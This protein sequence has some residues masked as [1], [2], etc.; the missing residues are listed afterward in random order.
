MTGK[1]A[2]LRTSGI[3]GADL[4][5][6][7][8]SASVLGIGSLA[9]TWLDGWAF[10]G[11]V[12]IMAALVLREWR[13]LIG[14]EQSHTVAVA[15]LAAAIA[16]ILAGHQFGAGAAGIVSVILA[17]AAALHAA[18]TSPRPAVPWA[19][20]GVLYAIIPAVAMQSLR[21]SN[22]S[23]LAA[24]LFVFAVVWS[25]D[26][27][28]YMTGRAIG[29]PRLM[30]VISPK[31]TWAGAIGGLGGALVGAAVVCSVA[32]VPHIWPVLV[33]AAA[34]SIVAQAGDLT[35]SWIKRRFSVKDS[36]GL[37]PGHGG[38]MDRVDGLVAAATF[39]AVVGWIHSGGG[40]AAEG[41]LI[42]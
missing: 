26:V 42:W 17:A 36:G 10:S 23:G 38:V 37:I 32:A 13:R 4:R 5:L 28:A 30:A 20:A 9:V 27:F 34:A 31:K 29:G 3:F 22:A 8:L 6:R 25:T 11:L 39:L 1:Q 21:G 12:A 15:M 35:E 19:A 2:D 33:L 41:V 24:V 7:T 18:A 14:I 16:A 40:D